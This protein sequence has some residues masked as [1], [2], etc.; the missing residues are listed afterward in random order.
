MTLT[1]RLRSH[2][3]L[4]LTL[5]AAMAAAFA[6][7]YAWVQRWPIRA[8]LP[9]LVTPVD[10]AI[11]FSPGWVWAYLS[12]YGL[13][14]AGWLAATRAELWRYAAGYAVILAA[15]LLCFLL[16]PVASPR[17]AVLP[18]AAVFDAVAFLDLTTNTVPSLH[19]AFAVYHA[20][21][22]ER[23]VAPPVWARAGLWLW[24]A[25][26]AYA[27]LATKQHWFVDVPTG[28]LL[29]GVGDWLAWRGGRGSQTAK[30]A[31]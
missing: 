7:G 19:V 23:L 24:V 8:P 9:P 6:V 27:T 28:A 11:P 14:G 29:G 16:W 31:T 21:L 5:G 13:L 12:L 18:D 4:K 15:A 20:R 25:A 17:P 2:W 10:R 30:G 1:V 22:V 3:R 26:I